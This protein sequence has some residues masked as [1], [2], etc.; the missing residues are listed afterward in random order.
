MET[1]MRRT[2]FE[3]T[4]IPFLIDSLKNNTKALKIQGLFTHY[5]GAESQANHFRVKQQIKHFQLSLNAFEAEGLKPKYYHTSCSAALINYPESPGNMVR[6]GILQYGF[7]PND[8]THIRYCGEQRKNLKLLKRLIKW[9]SSVMSIKHIQKGCF[10]GYGTS[11]LA[12]KD[13]KVAIVPV[14]YAHGYSRNLSNVGKVLIK[15]KSAPVIAIINM[16]SLTVDITHIKEVQKG[17]EVML[18]GKQNG[19][20]ITVSSFSEKTNQLNYEML[21]RLPIN[22]PRNITA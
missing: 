8:E 14:G 22:I 1:G 18:I 13:M 20:E 9:S 3:Y 21:T 17:D 12:H 2:G 4:A 7:W 10:V 5:A 15:G 19:N 11:Y 16:N 6:I